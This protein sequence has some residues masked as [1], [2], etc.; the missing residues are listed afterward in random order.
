[1]GRGRATRPL[2]ALANAPGLAKSCIPA[3]ASIV[4]T[5]DNSH[6]LFENSSLRL[7]S[8]KGMSVMTRETTMAASQPRAPDSTVAAAERRTPSRRATIHPT[9]RMAGSVVARKA[10]QKNQAGSVETALAEPTIT[11][12]AHSGH[13]ARPTAR[14][15]C[16]ARGAVGHLPPLRA[17]DRQEPDPRATPPG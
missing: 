10:G 11:I 1:M 6:T 12:L 13:R 3:A 16:P 2:W 4:K 15:A 5:T 14:R 17:T 8:R 7:A 9:T